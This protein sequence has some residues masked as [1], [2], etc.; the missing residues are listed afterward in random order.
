MPDAQLLYDPTKLSL[1]TGQLEEFNQL[2][3]SQPGY[4]GGL[5]VD[6]G[7]GRRVVINLWQTEAQAIAARDALEPAVRWLLEPLMAAP[8]K[9][10]GA[11][12]VIDN[13]LTGL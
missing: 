11:G 9:L 5:I 10:V 6:V 2:H 3:S 7:K 1:A 8:A 4:R 13:D 12:P